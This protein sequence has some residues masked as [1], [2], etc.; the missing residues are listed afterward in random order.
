MHCSAGH[1][2]FEVFEF[3]T[4]DLRSKTQMAKALKKI[5]TDML[6]D[7]RKCGQKDNTMKLPL[8]L[9]DDVSFKRLYFENTFLGGHLF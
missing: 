2:G 1:I 6:T 8:I 3:S 9:I 7:L 4:L 5:E